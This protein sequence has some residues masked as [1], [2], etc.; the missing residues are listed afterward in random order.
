MSGK[1]DLRDCI[2]AEAVHLNSGGAFV[3]NISERIPSLRRMPERGS[4]PTHW[5]NSSGENT[6]STEFALRTACVLEPPGYD[7]SITDFVLSADD[8]A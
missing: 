3:V 7:L 4:A 1:G 6:E 5:Q 2:G 8:F